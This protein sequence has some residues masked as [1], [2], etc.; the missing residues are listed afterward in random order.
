MKLLTKADTAKLQSQFNRGS[1]MSQKVVVK[2]FNPYGKGRFYIMNQDPNDPDYMWGIVQMG[3]EIEVGSISL[4]ELEN[5]KIGPYKLG[6][7]RDRSF[8]PEKA[9]VVFDGL[10]R[11]EFFADG[12]MTSVEIIN[13]DEVFDEKRYP[14]IFGDFDKDGVSNIDDP[15]PTKRGDKETIEQVELK[16]VFKKILSVKTG[17]DSRMKS[18]VKKLVEFSPKG[19]KIYARTKTPYSILNKLVA[20]RLIDPVNP[21]RGLTDLIGTTIVV[22]D[23]KGLD[24]VRDKLLD[25]ALGQVIDYEDFYTKPKAGYMAYH[26][27]IVI[28]DVP[29]EVQLKTERQKKLNL[30]S[31][32]PYKKE[33]LNAKRL[34]ELSTMANEADMG[35]DVVAKKIDMILKDQDSLEKELTLNE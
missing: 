12:G 25:G 29:T 23:K 13:E 1:D 4:S 7:E 28:D 18:A 8:T 26:F 21:S 10:N 34:L 6:L 20:K 9:E 2:I 33:K 5:V 31:H 19:S 15:N 11:G 35:D 16:D 30:A 17:L 32:E 22:K 3:D 14:A 24:E 27:I